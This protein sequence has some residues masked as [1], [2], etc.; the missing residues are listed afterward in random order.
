MLQYIQKITVP[1]E[2][3][4]PLPQRIGLALQAV[5]EIRATTIACK[6]FDAALTTARSGVIW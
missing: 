3:A 1:S 6:E 5:A 2:N 4:F